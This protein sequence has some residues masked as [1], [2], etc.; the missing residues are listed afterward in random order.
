VNFIQNSVGDSKNEGFFLNDG[1]KVIALN[2][3]EVNE[4]L[5]RNIKKYN[6]PVELN[7]VIVYPN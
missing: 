6:N 4:F 2:R 1:T 7:R 5:R 3:G